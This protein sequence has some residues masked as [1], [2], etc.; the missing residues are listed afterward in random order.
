MQEHTCW[1]VERE[2]LDSKVGKRL[3]SSTGVVQD[4]EQGAVT[5]LETALGESSDQSLRLLDVR[6]SA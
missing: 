5:E 4:Q 2:L 6:E 3:N 1:T